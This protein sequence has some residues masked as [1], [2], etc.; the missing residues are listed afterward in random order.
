MFPAEV[1]GFFKVKINTLSQLVSGTYT[2]IDAMFYNNNGQTD[3]T[4]YSILQGNTITIDNGVQ[5]VGAPTNNRTVIYYK[6]SGGTKIKYRLTGGD[7]ISQP[8]AL[9]ASDYAGYQLATIDTGAAT[10]VAEAAFVNPAGVWDNN[11]NVNYTF[12][13]GIY[14]LDGGVLKLGTP[15]T[16][17]EM[18]IYY[19]KTS[20][21]AYIHFRLNGGAWTTSPGLPMVNAPVSG[22]AKITVPLGTSSG[23]EAVFNNGAGV[24]DN[25]GGKNYLLSKGTTIIS[26]ATV[27]NG[28]PVVKSVQASPSSLQLG[29]G[30]SA[31]LQINATDVMGVYDASANTTFVSSNS[32]SLRVDSRG[33]C[34][35]VQPGTGVVTAKLGTFTLS[36]PFTVTAPELQG[37]SF[38]SDINPLILTKGEQSKLGIFGH[39]SNGVREISNEISYSTSNSSV[40]AIDAAGTITAK[41]AGFSIITLRSG[42]RT[43]TITVVVN[44]VKIMKFSPVSLT[45]GEGLNGYSTLSAL[46]TDGSAKEYIGTGV[47]YESNHPEIA[48]VDAYGSVT[49]VKPGQATITA[50]Y[51]GKT[52]SFSVAITRLLRLEASPANITVGEGSTN[53]GY[54]TV[55]GIYEDG[56]TQSIGNAVFTS[57]QTGIAEVLNGNMIKGISKGT[58]AI[59]VKFG[60]QTLDVPVAVKALVSLEVPDIKLYEANYATPNLTMHYED[61]STD[62][63]MYGF[64]IQSLNPAVVNVVYGSTVYGVKAGNTQVRINYSGK[65][66]IVPVQVSGLVSIKITP[67]PLVLKMFVANSLSTFGT[68]DDGTVQ[69]LYYNDAFTYQVANPELIEV[70][71]YGLIRGLVK[72]T[73]S[74]TLS[75]NGKRTLTSAQV[76]DVQSLSAS[77]NSIDVGEGGSTQSGITVGAK[78]SDGTTEYLYSSSGLSMQ[79]ADESIAMVNANGVVRGIKPGKTTIAVKFAGKSLTIPVNVKALSSIASLQN[80]IAMGIGTT[81]F[82][83]INALYSDKTTEVIMSSNVKFTAD[84]T[85]VITVDSYG[86]IRAI[87]PGTANV[88]VS[89]AG[90]TMTIAV[91]VFGLTS[92]ELSPSPL[93]MQKGGMSNL[94]VLATFTNNTKQAWNGPIYYVSSNES[95]VSATSYGMIYGSGVGNAVITAYIRDLQS[96]INVTVTQ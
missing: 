41:S 83:Q 64:E 42:T 72:G 30:A 88:Y 74:L 81:S 2:S 73:T 38:V 46:L 11:K 6:S 63:T 31:Q 93:Q 87:N 32:N 55:N 35:A 19:K 59:H 29:Q 36:I 16:A 96:Q 8:V 47:R 61:G 62:S 10:S 49:G 50:T 67:D 76:I 44:E 24:W 70:S 33:Y 94:L 60:A 85:G 43:K 27:T 68:Y 65:N 1:P 22:Y 57:N 54:F 92:I 84:A 66:V 48:T 45:I 28:V 75:Y 39:F 89:Y 56:T 90:K 12:Q 58:T 95:V 86:A 4:Q 80:S 34:I 7:W 23:L 71:Q 77:V 53:G 51:G 79:S 9:D 52:C 40:A 25:N 13:N 26:G 14:T 20:T 91:Q 21:S 15:T 18:T 3:G 5:K 37:W 78:Y 17:N 69:S 82:T